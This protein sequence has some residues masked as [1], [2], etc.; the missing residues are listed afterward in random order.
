[1]YVWLDALTNYI[2]ALGYPDTED[3]LFQHF[4]PADLHMVGKD[5]LRFHAVYWPAI[6]MSAGLEPPK[7]IFAHGWWTNEGSK[8]SK[9]LGNVIEP[10]TLIN[11]YGLDA[12]RYFLLRE[13]PFGSDGDFSHNAVISRING[14]LAN[15]YGNLAHRVLSMIA[16]NCGGHIPKPGVLRAADYALLEHA[17]ELV[18]LLRADFAVQAFH[19]ALEA[20]W[21]VVADANRYID[22]QAPWSLSKTDLSR[23]ETVLYV[24]A[25]TL[26][27]LAILMQP[28]MPDAISH[29]LDQLAIS[30]EA[31]YFSY[32]VPEHALRPGTVLPPPKAIF[33]R[34]V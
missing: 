17:S 27:Y 11:I 4:W 13:V 1:M 9:S 33:P 15:G 32:L 18:G 23:M 10:L 28:V 22:E 6:L 21:T 24:L 12:V 25:E 20:I 19:K 3:Q 7:R 16:K 2:T 5:I 31:R 8:I 30:V 29:L 26:R 34:F 14:D